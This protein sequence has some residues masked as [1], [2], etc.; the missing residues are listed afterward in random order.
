MTL[1][2]ADQNK[3]SH[4]YLSD[5]EYQVFSMLVSGRSLTKIA[6]KLSL[7]VKTISAHRTHILEKMKMKNNAQLIQCAILNGL[8]Q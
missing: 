8:V 1:D 4:E 2:F 3:P 5:R 6:E 7:S